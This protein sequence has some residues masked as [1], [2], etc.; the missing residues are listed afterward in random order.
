L[1]AVVVAQNSAPVLERCLASLGFADEI[2][3][4]DGMSHD[5]TTDLARKLGARVVPHLWSGYSEQKQF[6][7]EQATGDWVFLCDTDE[8]VTPPLAREITESIRQS[9]AA[10]GYRVKRR[11]Q[12]LG[13]WIDVGPWT[14]DVELRLF[15]RGRG[16]MTGA[17]V[18]EGVAV[19]G[20]VRTLSNVLH[21]YTH[22]SISA[23]VERLNRY[24]SLEAADR[25][26][27]RRIHALDAVFP[28]AGVFFNYYVAKGCWRAGMRGFLLAAITAMYKSTL[29]MKLYWLQRETRGSLPSPRGG[30]SPRSANPP[31]AGGSSLA[32]T[33]AEGVTPTSPPA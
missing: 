11:N 24:T 20:A 25:V 17:S 1:S 32:P 14:D 4:V 12:F 2:V 30:S 16:R 6:A 5:G 7:I 10:D 19:Q 26:D 15:K 13:D 23:S 8:E 18:H 33:K 29:Y 28:P 22:P 21:H 3:V 31:V 9:S 27:R